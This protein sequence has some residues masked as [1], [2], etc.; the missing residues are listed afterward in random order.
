MEGNNHSWGGDKKRNREAFVCSSCL[1]KEHKENNLPLFWNCLSSTCWKKIKVKGTKRTCPEKSKLKTAILKNVHSHFTFFDNFLNL[2]HLKTIYLGPEDI[3][4]LQL[5]YQVPV[6]HLSAR[7]QFYARTSP[8]ECECA[9]SY[10]TLW[11]ERLRLGHRGKGVVTSTSEFTAVPSTTGSAHALSS[12][13]QPGSL[14]QPRRAVRASERTSLLQSCEVK[15]ET[16]YGAERGNHDSFTCP[17]HP[18]SLKTGILPKNNLSYFMT[19][20]RM[21]IT[22]PFCFTWY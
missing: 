2:L 1:S 13:R 11:D 21:T 17:S 15:A 14:G 7:C 22:I 4:F 16:F 12:E 19:A 9:L 20:K 8:V 10:P 3:R 6:Q 18:R 5:E